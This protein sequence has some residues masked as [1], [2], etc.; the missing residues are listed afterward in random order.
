MGM[1][2]CQGWVNSRGLMVWMSFGCREGEGLG[3]VLTEI[4]ALITILVG[5]MGSF[6]LREASGVLGIFLS[7]SCSLKPCDCTCPRQ[8]LLRAEAAIRCF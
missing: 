8:A 6:S 7:N 1:P 3:L 5:A 2:G 4:L